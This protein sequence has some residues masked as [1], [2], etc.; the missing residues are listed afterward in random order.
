MDFELA[1]KT[2]VRF[3]FGADEAYNIGKLKEK[4][5][6]VIIA[7]GAWAKGECPV[8]E[9]GEK[10]VDAL[11][12]LEASKA[13]GCGM[14]LGRKVAVIGGGDVAMDCART[15]KR[16]P[17]V[18]KVSIVYRRTREFMPAQAEEIDMALAEGIEFL[19]LL[20]PVSYDGKMLA[21]EKMV[22]GE[23]GADGRRKPVPAGETIH[24]QYDTVISAVG[25]QVDMD[26]FRRGGLATE[27]DGFAVLDGGN[28]SSLE[29]VYVAG[30]C[31]RGAATIVQAAADSKAIALHILKRLNM[32]D[33]F[34]R[35]EVPLD[36]KEI[37]GRRGVLA[38][39]KMGP[40]KCLGCRQA[41]EVC[42][43]VCPNRANVSVMAWGRPQILHI[44]GMC[45]ECGNCA[46]FCPHN[47]R[48]YKDKT[49]LFWDRE[50]FWNSENKGFAFLGNGKLLVR[51]ENG[52][53][54]EG[55]EDD[56]RISDEMRGMIRAVRE[57]NG[58]LLV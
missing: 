13:C 16:S 11:A 24:L 47:G 43:E 58:Y 12:F 32:T 31:R 27:E 35:A 3:V 53:A 2:G 38:E 26:A 8:R 54:F 30:D 37:A 10:L 55:A 17:G 21:L 4:F 23:A 46:T 39:G 34:V 48:P 20:A 9:G 28:Q 29:G 36:L 25:A 45:N 5:E 15:A 7:T 14:Q 22:L 57:E 44:D 18:Q 49:T 41:C 6:F 19:E 50:S 33:D 42:C 1:E 51:P 56:K 52:A 40:D